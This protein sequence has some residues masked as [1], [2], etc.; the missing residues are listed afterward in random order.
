MRLSGGMEK[1]LPRAGGDGPC[2]LA[3]LRKA[4]R[5]E[6]LVSKRL[7]REDSAAQEGGQDGADVV[8]DPLSED[9]V[10]NLTF[11]MT[12]GSRGSSPDSAYEGGW[13]GAGLGVVLIHCQT[14]LSSLCPSFCPGFLCLKD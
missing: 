14:Q 4:R 10:K 13:A 7:L 3:A 8:P 5:Q 1:L 12:V 9:E 11:S 6:Q 2:P